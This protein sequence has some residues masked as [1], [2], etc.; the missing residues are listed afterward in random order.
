MVQ[1]RILN[2]DSVSFSTSLPFYDQLTPGNDIPTPYFP[3]LDIYSVTT[4][5]PQRQRALRSTPRSQRVLF[6]CL[7]L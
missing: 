5:Y 2:M 4:L 7:L 6:V 1:A 3:L